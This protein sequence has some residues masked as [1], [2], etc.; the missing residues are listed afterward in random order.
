ML[1]PD[2]GLY[3]VDGGS[4]CGA[5][6]RPDQDLERDS[7]QYRD[8]NDYAYI[9]ANQQIH[10]LQPSS[11]CRRHGGDFGENSGGGGGEGGRFESSRREILLPSRTPTPYSTLERNTDCGPPPP[12]VVECWRTESCCSP[13]KK[14]LVNATLR[15]P[16]HSCTESVLL[17]SELNRRP[18]YQTKSAIK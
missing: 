3:D 15:S 4:D 10:G 12:A 9:D 5:V 8:L 13:T 14:K 18:S 7:D 1:S 17:S 16:S 6:P 11:S 2:A